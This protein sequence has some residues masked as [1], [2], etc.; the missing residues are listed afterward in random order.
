LRA[1]NDRVIAKV[2]W[3]PETVS[4]IAM[5]G[6]TLVDGQAKT[7]LGKVIA[8]GPGVTLRTGERI[9]VSVKVGD[10]ISWEQFG[11][12]RYEILG[13]N[14]VC[15]RSEDIGCVLDESEHAG[16]L[17]D[18]SEIAK[19]KN[20]RAAAVTKKTDEMKNTVVEDKKT[21]YRCVDRDCKD[22]GKEQERVIGDRTCGGCGGY[23]AVQITR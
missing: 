9:D 18:E 6:Q 12:L 11:G 21:I 23:M 3:F 8:V 2:G 14:V 13:E 22:N 1:L 20:E 4:G 17:F 5:A 10:I 16:W 7:N 19:V 15:I